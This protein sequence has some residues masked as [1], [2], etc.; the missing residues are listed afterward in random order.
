MNNKLYTQFFGSLSLVIF[1]FLGYVVKFYPTWIQ[2]FD[3]AVTSFVRQPY[4]NWNTFYL[5]ITKF[6]NPVT[7]VVLALA[8]LIVLLYGKQYAEAAWLSAGVIGISGLFNPLI[9]LLFTRERPTLEHLVTEHSY[10]F[11]SGHST[12]SM[13][14]YGTLICILPLFVK[15]KTLQTV[16]QIAL[17]CLIIIIGTS[18]IYLGVHF[19]S[20]ILGGFTLGLGW[21]LMTYPIYQKQRFIWRFKNKQS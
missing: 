15:N 19:P 4:P 8:F 11:P 1:A 2:P 18:R 7:I 14:L 9:K 5:W 21:L 12:A 20:D 13:V 16:L 6:A 3:N 10:S 17:I